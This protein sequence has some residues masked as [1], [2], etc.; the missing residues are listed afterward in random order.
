MSVL[1]E[2]QAALEAAQRV[3]AEQHHQQVV[4]RALWEGLGAAV[5]LRRAA[6]KSALVH[7]QNRRQQQ[8]WFT[9]WSGGQV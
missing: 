4:I 9:L 1:H 2:E 8:V 5:A 6:N 7:C 3:C